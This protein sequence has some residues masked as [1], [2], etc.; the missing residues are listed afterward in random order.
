MICMLFHLLASSDNVTSYVGHHV[1]LINVTFSFTGAKEKRFIPVL[2]D[3][4]Y[5]GKIP[6]SFSHITYL[7]F[8]RLEEFWKKLATSL[9]WNQHKA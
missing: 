3:E 1:L 9:G 5:R 7:D 8:H 4:D 6:R 2:I